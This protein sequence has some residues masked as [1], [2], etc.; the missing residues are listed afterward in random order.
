MNFA[1]FDFQLSSTE[2]ADLHE[3][4][5]ATQTPCVLHAG[6]PRK[7]VSAQNCSTADRSVKTLPYPCSILASHASASG[8]NSWSFQL[9]AIRSGSASGP[10]CLRTTCSL[11]LWQY[12]GGTIT[13]LTQCA[14]LTGMCPAREASPTRQHFLEIYCMMNSRFRSNVNSVY[15]CASSNSGVTLSTLGVW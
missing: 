9:T 12:S 4:H 8:P 13:Q 1:V 6:R 10:Y 7:A 15:S 3:F 2:L 11:W 5:Q 14:G